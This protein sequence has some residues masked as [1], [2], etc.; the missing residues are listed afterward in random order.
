MNGVEVVKEVFV[1]MEVGYD[2]VVSRDVSHLCVVIEKVG[3]LMVLSACL[4]DVLII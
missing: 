4:A 2:D 1:A 3:E